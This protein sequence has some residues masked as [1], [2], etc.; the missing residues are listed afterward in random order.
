M[1]YC[2]LTPRFLGVRVPSDVISHQHDS[3]L[4]AS[5]PLN[6][7]FGVTGTLPKSTSALALSIRRR[8]YHIATSVATHGLSVL[9]SLP[10]LSLYPLSC[11]AS[12][13][14]WLGSVRSLLENPTTGQHTKNIRLSIHTE[15]FPFR[16]LPLLRCS[17]DVSF[18]LWLKS[19]EIHHV[20][21]TLGISLATA[22]RN[23]S[24]RKSLP[25]LLV[26]LS[27]SFAFA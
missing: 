7:F 3:L 21:R 14:S 16:C 20:V 17:R 13:P 11:V 15:C 19:T 10:L 26:N 25:P 8:F 23:F 22:L 5:L 24:S 27:T 18:Q 12:V 1:T 9:P 6:L 2:L 4:V